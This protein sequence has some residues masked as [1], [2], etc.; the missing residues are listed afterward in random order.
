M[1]ENEK[2]AVE[3][4]GG[5]DRATAARRLY[6]DTECGAWIE[7]EDDGIRIGSIVEGCDF[8]TAIYPLKYP[9]EEDAFDERI[10]AIEAEAD[11]LWE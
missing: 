2:D 8:G 10:K 11:A 3:M 4:L 5:A 7:F 6:K 1:I 9:F